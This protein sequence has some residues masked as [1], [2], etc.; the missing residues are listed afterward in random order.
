MVTYG[1]ALL[2]FSGFLFSW[3]AAVVLLTV[4]W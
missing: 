3:F 4:S 1:L 2:A